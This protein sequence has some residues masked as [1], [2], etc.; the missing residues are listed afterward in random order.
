VGK[1]LVAYNFDRLSDFDFECLVRDLLGAELGVRFEHFTRGRDKGI[2]LRYAPSADR[3]TIVQCKHYLGTGYAGLKHNIKTKEA[4]KVRALAPQRLILAT[5]VPLTPDRKGELLHL[6]SPHVLTSGDILGLTE[7]EA[8]IAK[9]PT[10]ERVHFKLWLTSSGVLDRLVHSKVY[11][12]SDFLRRDIEEH[13]KYYVQNDSFPKALDLLKKHRVCIVAGP[14]GIGKTTLA[15]M[16]MLQLGAEGFVPVLISED[17]SE[18]TTVWNSEEKQFFYYDDFLGQ[19]ASHE[20]LGKNEDDRLATFLRGVNKTPN[21]VVVLTTREYILQQARARY[22]RL[23]RTEFDP[24][25]CVVALSDYTNRHRAQILYNHLYF[26]DTPR[27]MLKTLRG[28]G[29]YRRIIEHPKYNPR[30]VEYIAA[31]ARERC[32]RAEEFPAYVMRV[33]DDPDYLWAHPFEHQ[34]DDD[35]RALLVVLASLPTLTPLACFYNALGAAASEF[36]EGRRLRRT[37][38]IL[39]GDFVRTQR[40]G[41]LEVIGFA[42]PSLRDFVVGRLRDDPQLCRGLFERAIYF[43]QVS[44]LAGYSQGDAIK[45]EHVAALRRTVESESCVVETI[46]GPGKQ[47]HGSVA[48][49]IIESRLATALEAGAGDDETWLDNQLRRLRYRWSQ[50]RIDE[51]CDALL[52]VLGDRVHTE[53][54]SELVACLRDALLGGF[55]SSDEARLWRWLV[56]NHPDA[57]VGFE[58]RACTEFYAFADSEVD[59]LM[60]S[61]YEDEIERGREDLKELANK[62]GCDFG[63]INM[64]AVDEQLVGF[65]Q[66]AMAHED[67]WKENYHE[68]RKEREQDERFIDDLF[69]GLAD[70][71][72]G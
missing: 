34:L 14:P 64:M 25:T 32:A 36:S 19:T 28:E 53:I 42:N 21:K 45:Q 39:D 46:R 60:Q 72:E 51:G 63:A 37:L 69:D 16:L 40:H 9:H 66:Y 6:L 44:L 4:P 70:K 15:Q 31:H 50:H 43:D 10:V 3:K 30:L 29:L 17:I 48:T 57:C 27:E 11:N 54:G 68:E 65:A 1:E 20:K 7:I 67:D 12:Q 61:K 38:R 2:D 22:E 33:L 56:E 41:G 18:G 23:F 13:A 24:W 62:F 26:S 59:A 71:D 52:E 8:L 58:E 35:C 49:P 5:S 47:I 55:E